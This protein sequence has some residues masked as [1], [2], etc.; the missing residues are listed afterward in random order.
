MLQV[1]SETDL[2]ALLSAGT[3]FDERGPHNNVPAHSDTL[4]SCGEQ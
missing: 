1:V 4:L 3:F 2:V